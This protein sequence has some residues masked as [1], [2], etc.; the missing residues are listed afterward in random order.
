[1][2]NKQMQNTIIALLVGLAVWEGFLKDQVM[3]LLKK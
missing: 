3:K 2:R 1:M